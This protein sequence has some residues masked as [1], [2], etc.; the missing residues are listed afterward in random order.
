MQLV[1]TLKAERESCV[2]AFKRPGELD[3]V[4]QLPA[5]EFFLVLATP[6]QLETFA[7]HAFRLISIDG[8]FNVSNKDVKLL[9]LVVP[10]ERHELV[11]VAFGLVREE[12]ELHVFAFLA[13]VKR[14][15]DQARLRPDPRVLMSDDNPAIENAAVRVWSSI[16]LAILCAC[17]VNKA[18][19]T[20]LRKKIPKRHAEL[21]ETIWV[22]LVVILLR[23][24]T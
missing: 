6:W 23:V 22:S 5:D 2:L 8:T 24:R 19:K 12:S 14:G 17:H 1:A 9:S 21:R 11:P 13:A 7:A 18:W 20:N 16:K 10:N 4:T 15:C 3:N